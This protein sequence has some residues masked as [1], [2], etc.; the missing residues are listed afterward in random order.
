MEAIVTEPADA[1]ILEGRRLA[2]SYAGWAAT[3]GLVP[4]PLLD[5]A[6]LMT[7]QLAMLRSL[8]KLYGVP[9]DRERAKVVLSAA[10]GS[11]APQG[12]ASVAG[13]SGLKALPGWG[14]LLGITVMPALAVASTRAVADWFID[15]LAAG[16]TLADADP[17]P[18]RAEP[19]PSPV[20]AAEPPARATESPVLAAG[21]DPGAAPQPAADEEP[22]ESELDA[23]H[24]RARRSPRTRRNDRHGDD[25]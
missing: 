15:H 18:Q 12:V 7:T 10:A 2:K 24:G 3:A 20:P 1:R 23:G 19:P 4:L 14:G 9:F 25:D 6:G 11:V 13:L 5:V 17:R 16:G 22:S 8:T 21:A